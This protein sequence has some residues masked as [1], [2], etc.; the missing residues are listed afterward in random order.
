L[1]STTSFAKGMPRSSR[2]PS[3]TLGSWR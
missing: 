3:M 1:Q 2:S